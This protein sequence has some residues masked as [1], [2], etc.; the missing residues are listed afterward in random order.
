MKER[1][2]LIDENGYMG[3]EIEFQGL[4]EKEEIVEKGSNKSKSENAL[5]DQWLS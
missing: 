5:V 1:E 2:C 4:G 3:R